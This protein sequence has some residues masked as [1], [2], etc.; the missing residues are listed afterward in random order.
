MLAR[1]KITLLILAVLLVATACRAADPAPPD[2]SFLKQFAE[3]RRFQ[4]GRPQNPKVSPDGKTVLFLR[5]EPG[6]PALKL[7]EFDF[8]TAKTRE[9]LSPQAL[10]KGG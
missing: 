8:A 6:K 3:T 5:A 10:L 9:L 1:M 2:T 4:L 7:F